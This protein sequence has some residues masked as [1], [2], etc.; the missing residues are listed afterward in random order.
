[1][2]RI[3]I[4]L[5]AVIV[6]SLVTGLF[7]SIKLVHAEETKQERTKL[8][9]E[10]GLTLSYRGEVGKEMA[11]W[12]LDFAHQGQKDSL[13]QQVR[14]RIT[15]E[16]EQP[17]DYP[18]L[19]GMTEKDGWLIEK[20]FS[21]QSEGQVAF[22]LPKK[23]QKLYLYV[24]LNQQSEE[25]VKELLGQE[26]P[27]ILELDGEKQA[28]TTSQTQKTQTSSDIATVSTTEFVGPKKNQTQ[29]TA[30]ATAETTKEVYS[31]LY[32]NK[33]TQYTTDSSGT[34]PEFAWQ[35]QGQ[36]NVLNHQG[37]DENQ[38]GWDNVK[39]WDVT[40]DNHDQSYIKYGEDA[41]N[42]NVQLRKYA[43]QTAVEDEFKIKL[44]VRGNT[45]YK[46]GVDI[47]FLLDNSESMI[48]AESGDTKNRKTYANEA[49][50]KIITELKKVYVPSEKN[51]RIGGE[52]FSEYNYYQ[53]WGSGYR[54]GEK[55]TFQLSEN[56]SDW[57]KLNSEYKRANPQ[58]V[59]FTQRGLTEANDIFNDAA[60][61]E[62]RHKLLF[63]LTDGA[64]NRSWVPKDKGTPNNEMFVDKLHFENFDTGPKGSYKEGSTLGTL[65]NKTTIVPAYNGVLNSHITTT[66]STAM[67]MKNAGVQIHTIALQ[68]SVNVNEQNKRDE[69]LRGLYKMSTKKANGEQD[70]DKDTAEDFF[71]YNVDKGSELTEYFK[72][73]YETIIRTVNKGKITDPLGDMVEFVTDP[74]KQP[75]VTQVDNGAEQID[76]ED[77]PTASI[78]DNQVKV[79][80]I[81]LT[82][83]QEIEVEYTVRLKTDDPNFVS[84]HWYQTNKTTTLDP[85]PERTTDLIEFG[86]PSVKL[87]TADFVI[88]V[89]K[90]WSDTS[91]ETAN[92]WALRAKEVTAT[93]QKW[94][95]NEWQEVQSVQLNADND[96]ETKFSA[97]KG[98]DDNLYRVVEG[99]RTTGYKQPAIN[100]R[101][102]TSE[103]IAAAGIEITNELLTGSYSFN[104]YMED[105]KTPFTT[106]LPQFQL[107]R[108]DGKIVAQ[109]V[110]PNNEG[111]VTFTD[112]AIGDYVVEETYVPAGFQKMAD[113]EI[114]VTEN[115]AAEGLIFTVN[116]STDAYTAI[117]KLKDF[118][119]KVEKI[120]PADNLLAG[121]S[122]KLTGPNYEVIQVDGPEFSFIG[123]RPGSYRLTEIE[124]PEGYQKI[125][126]P[127]L[128]DIGIDGKVTITPH[129][130]ATGTV[131]GNKIE[132]KVTNK[133]VRPGALPNTGASGIRLF[134]LIAGACVSF[135]VLLSGAYAYFN[136]KLP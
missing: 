115:D 112:L 40:A 91:R 125:N 135:G 45:T 69:L 20:E 103:T 83:D 48:N 5:V 104:K 36:A 96:W 102:F 70:P 16:E 79:D 101:E 29:P 55:R 3:T 71:F 86:I 13:E 124:S 15:D 34:Y 136:H 88:P 8:L 14:I 82:G 106:D 6:F 37:G 117:N 98:G 92:Y 80:N 57:D 126:E 23:T 130:A 53:T 2:K 119:L 73:W 46:P 61:S 67:D 7:S 85:T 47:V 75:K 1:M 134:Y 50:D 114:K 59:T 30:K 109:N 108:S 131:D 12:S 72:N 22:D 74:E 39:S 121:A 111:K 54:P 25:G 38:A 93:L 21:H 28:T 51:I 64:P 18:E 89:K 87:Q 58:G 66:N 110:R 35:P 99:S 123:L 95:G 90:I 42:P 33:V 19:D 60:N 43:Q 122:F 62:G 44:N 17:I 116:N 41:A 105:G 113:F 133:K 77:M 107:T 84:N 63:V 78:V 127:I 100:Q 4:L 118:T 56:T 120:D 10:K 27:Y 31:P 65:G 52:I 49:L 68:I 32:T 97:V 81:N 9:D 11:H 128:F 26:A 76:E 24:Q 132:L 94:D 129:P